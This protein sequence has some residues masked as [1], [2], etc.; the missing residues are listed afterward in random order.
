M[1]KVVIANKWTD[2]AGKDYNGGDLVDVE[3]GVARDLI[4]RAKARP[5]PNPTKK[6]ATASASKPASTGTKSESP[7]PATA[8]KEAKK[9][10]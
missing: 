10:G 3:P 8:G 9:D 4:A 2:P 6:P 1:T 7:K 5:A